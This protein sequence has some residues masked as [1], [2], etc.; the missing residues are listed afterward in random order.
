MNFNQTTKNLSNNHDFDFD[1]FDEKI[2]N[3]SEHELL[4]LIDKTLKNI[5]DLNNENRVLNEYY[6]TIQNYLDLKLIPQEMENILSKSMMLPEKNVKIVSERFDENISEVNKNFNSQ[7]M[8]KIPTGKK[9]EQ[10]E[11]I[12]S[13]KSDK[14]SQINSFNN[15]SNQ[16]EEMDINVDNNNNNNFEDEP[17]IIEKKNN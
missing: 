6:N 13:K 9:I 3:K 1:N 17:K 10:S 4:D 8:N 14:K 11:E 5:K 12:K 2:K 15:N 16:I 7:S